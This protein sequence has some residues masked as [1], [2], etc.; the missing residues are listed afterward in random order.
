MICLSLF[1]HFAV[2]FVTLLSMASQQ[3]TLMGNG[4]FWGKS[5]GTA[6]TRK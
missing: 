4:A 6:Q 2:F 1:G 3:S 5:K